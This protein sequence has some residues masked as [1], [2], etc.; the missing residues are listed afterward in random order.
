MIFFFFTGDREVLLKK[1]LV[2]KKLENSTFK[3]FLIRRWNHG[4]KRKITKFKFK[5]FKGPIQLSSHL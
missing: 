4:I 2:L 5:M 3:Q 1:K